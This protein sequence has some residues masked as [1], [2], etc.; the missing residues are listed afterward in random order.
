MLFSDCAF[1]VYD[2]AL[3][4][5]RSAAELMRQFFEL[6]VP[7]RMGLAYGTWHV[8]RFS[9]DVNAPLT[10]T[11]AA[12]YGTGVVRAVQTEKSGGK[13]MRIFVHRDL[14]HASQRIAGRLAARNRRE[15]R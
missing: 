15:H 7:V 4:A 9:F 5:A 1:A 10:I 13:G 14:P 12:F 6:A 3:S 8:R 11:R 2:T